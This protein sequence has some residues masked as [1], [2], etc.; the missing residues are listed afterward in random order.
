MLSDSPSLCRET[1][2]GQEF[3]TASIPPTILFLEIILGGIGAIPQILSA[4]T[5]L[6]TFLHLCGSY[7]NENISK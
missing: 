6:Q 7:I 4:N 1:C 5:D 2:Q 3:V